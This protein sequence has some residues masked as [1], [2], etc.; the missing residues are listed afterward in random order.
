MDCPNC[1]LVNPPTAARCDCG[2]DFQMRAMKEEPPGIAKLTKSEIQVAWFIWAFLLIPWFYLF[3]L[4]GMAWDGGN[5]LSVVDYVGLACIWT[6]PVMLVIAYV[7][8]RKL[9]VLI[10]LPLLNI[11]LGTLIVLESARK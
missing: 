5:S 2:Y 8:R 11:L 3:S 7:L 10:F 4:T 1:R 9:P 6:Y